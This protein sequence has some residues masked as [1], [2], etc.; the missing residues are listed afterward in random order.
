MSII[1]KTQ[2]GNC[3][4]WH[5]ESRWSVGPRNLLAAVK[6]AQA[7]QSETSGVGGFRTL[8]EIDGTVLSALDCPGWPATLAEA[9]AAL[10]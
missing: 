4:P 1:V 10:V 6:C 7:A 2:I 3:G 9:K 8:I 5:T